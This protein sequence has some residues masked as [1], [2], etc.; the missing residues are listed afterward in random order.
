MKERTGGK[1]K[2]RKLKLERRGT[3]KM[4]GEIRK[5]KKKGERGMEKQES[6]GNR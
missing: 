4:K 5:N 6:K 3:R 2:S 1:E